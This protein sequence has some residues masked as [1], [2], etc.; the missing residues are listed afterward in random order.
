MKTKA[1]ILRQ[2]HQPTL[3]LP[4]AWDAASARVFERAGFAAIGTTSAG[5]AFALGYADGQRIPRREMVEAV[6]RIV[7][8][9]RVPVTADMEG[10][11]GDPGCTA[12]EVWSAGAV[13]INIE[14]WDG[15]GL[16]DLLPSIRAIR[17]AVPDTVI[18]ARTD[19][20]LRQIGEESTR[21]GRAVD[22]LNAYRDVG[23]DCLFAPGVADRGM[24]AR[25]VKAVRGPLNVLAVSGTPPV[26]ELKAL[27][28]ARLS[29]GSGPMRATL[30]LLE[31]IARELHDDGA[32]RAMLSGAV[33]YVE[34]NLLFSRWK[35]SGG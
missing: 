24:I 34:A 23:A 14:D 12:R 2:L 19:I 9:V 1:A 17:A 7:R 16:F 22:R 6:A 30:G 35:E 29:T 4:N 18:N 13:G 5:V 27:G 21:F 33:P 8:S 25:L 31:A 26:A 32:Y 3:V 11:Y 20:F 28:V 15:E 10:G